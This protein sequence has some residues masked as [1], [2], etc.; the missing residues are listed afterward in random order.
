MKTRVVLVA[1]AVVAGISSLGLRGCGDPT[2]PVAWVSSGGP[3]TTPSGVEVGDG[4]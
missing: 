2:K 1:L 4:G 3:Q